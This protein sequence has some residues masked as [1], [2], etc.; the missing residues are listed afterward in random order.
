[1]QQI[2]RGIARIVPNV[3]AGIGVEVIALRDEI[4]PQFRLLLWC[5]L[6]TAAALLTI[7]CT[8]LA[9]LLLTRGLAR[10]RELAIR[11]ALGAGRQRLVRQMVTESLLLASAGGAAGVAFAMAAM[12]S[13]SHLVPATL[14]I[15]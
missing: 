13:V 6:A 4:S 14:P 10:Q 8:N 12:P 1:M 3:N 15:G 9:N 5:L 2:G 7:A 11:A